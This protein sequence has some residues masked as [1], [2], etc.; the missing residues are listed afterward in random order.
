MAQ[1]P[2]DIDDIP[3]LVPERDE[4]VLHRKQ[5]RGATASSS[6]G[7]AA[8]SSEGPSG[9][10]SGAVMFFLTLLFFGL[11][12]TGAGGYYFYQQSELAKAELIAAT[13]RITS[14]E[15]TL[16]QMDETTKQSAMGLLE[17]VDFNFSEIDKLWAARNALRTEVEKLTA[18]MTAVQKAAGDLETAVTSHGGQITQHNN[19][20]TQ[21]QGRLEEINKNF[22]GMANLGQQLTQLNADL[23]RV[24][25][26]MEDTNSRTKTAEEDIESINVYRLQLNQTITNL[27]S[28]ISALQQKVGP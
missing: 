12:G 15:G 28:S 5:K 7:S 8:D 6:R 3:S 20:V 23:N 14:I 26:S 24:K 13:N 19:Q 11:C 25:L 21:L 16:N 1:N 2:D 27:Q 4:L 22:A 9:R 10:T 17:K 18:S